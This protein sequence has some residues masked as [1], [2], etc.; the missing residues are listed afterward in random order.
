M[1]LTKPLCITAGHREISKVLN[2]VNVVHIKHYF[3]N[4]LKI[5]TPD[6]NYIIPVNEY[7]NENT[8]K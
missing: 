3:V 8:L 1:I 6:M 5:F 4:E 7:Y 2:N